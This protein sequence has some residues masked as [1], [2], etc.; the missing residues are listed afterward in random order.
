MSATRATSTAIGAALA[1]SGITADMRFVTVNDTQYG[2]GGGYYAVYAGGNARARGRGARG[3]AF[4]RRPGRRIWRRP[5]AP[6]PAPSPCQPNITI[7]P[8]GAKWAA[9]LGYDQPGIG[10]IGAY[11][12]GY[13]HDLG[14]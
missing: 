6:I 13:Y 10:V 5:D 11:E 3:R 12:G 7:D 2:G 14:I 8:T 1:G 9:W 4:L